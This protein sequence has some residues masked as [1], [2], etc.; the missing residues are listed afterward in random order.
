MS[1]LEER[2]SLALEEW[3]PPAPIT[4][5][6]LPVYPFDSILLPEALRDWVTDV[7]HRKDNSP[8]DFAAVGAMVSLSSLLGSKAV[9]APKQR[10]SWQVFPNL[11]GAIVGRPSSKKSPCLADILCPLERLEMI[12]METHEQAK[13]SYEAVKKLDDIQTK[14]AEARAKKLV[15]D[16]K[17]DEAR[18][19]LEDSARTQP[20][21]PSRSR[22]R[23]NNASV[24]KLG[25][26]LQENPAGLLQYRDE[27]TGW[28]AVLQREDRAEDRAFYL[29]GWNGGGHFT[30]DRIGRGTVDI[31]SVT[32]S[33]LGGIQPGKLLPLLRA[34]AEGTGDDGFLQRFQLLVYPDPP[35]FQRVDQA[36][37]TAARDRAYEV[38]QRFA[39]IPL[40]D[41]P[42]TYRFTQEGK[43]PEQVPFPDAQ[44]SAY[45]RAGGQSGSW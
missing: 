44:H 1:S 45:R 24:E 35:P 33:V 21:K 25:E 39:A 12:G 11:W 15:K 17:H 27:L 42:M 34:Q 37:D 3:P 8:T 30:Y 43:P 10:D 14:D 38:F 32:V 18:L 16:G 40:Q 13:I 41:E 6:L 36:P 26:L 23:V 31:P 20:E 9:I 4:Q 28:L 29:E 5:K 7:A 19:L 22:Y 2:A